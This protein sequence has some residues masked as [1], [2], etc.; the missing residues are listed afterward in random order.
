MKTVYIYALGD[1]DTCEIRYIGKS[2]R[3]AEFG[4]HRTTISKIK[5][6]TYHAQH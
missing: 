4:V 6:G 2:V 1:P 5:M 3:P